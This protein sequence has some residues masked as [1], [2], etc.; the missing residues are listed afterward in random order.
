MR[1]IS[2][3]TALLAATAALF[4][5]FISGGADAVPM[6]DISDVSPSITEPL[7]SD[8][9]TIT[10][11]LILVDAEV[12]EGDVQLGWFPC[13][14]AMC[15][16]VKYLDMTR[17]DNGTWTVDLGPFDEV[18]A[19]GDPYVK[20]TFFVEVQGHATDGSEDPEVERSDTQ[21][22]YFGS[23]GAHDDDTPD[24]DAQ[25]DG[26]GED[27]PLGLGAVIAGVLLMTALII[28]VRPRA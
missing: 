7:H 28:R 21:N 17:I 12:T 19:T 22:L 15:D 11:T 26:D 25:P 23:G 4:L 8:T 9:I 10:A 14:D 24:D 16:P 3:H 5:L 27:S 18:S 13:T 2:I 6:V 1:P 20:I